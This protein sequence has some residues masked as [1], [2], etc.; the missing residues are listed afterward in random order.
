MPGEIPAFC[1]S[2]I[3]AL[4]M[5]LIRFRCGANIDSKWLKSKDNISKYFYSRQKLTQKHLDAIY[6]PL[7]LELFNES[8][9]FLI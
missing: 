8:S 1:F 5:P 4:S 6:L 3:H 9:L 2:G 7:L